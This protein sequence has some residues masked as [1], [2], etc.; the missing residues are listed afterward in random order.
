MVFVCISRPFAK[1]DELHREGIPENYSI[2]SMLCIQNFSW[3]PMLPHFSN[4]VMVR[5]TIVKLDFDDKNIGG[6]I[7]LVSVKPAEFV[8]NSVVVK[9]GCYLRSKLGK[10]T[11]RLSG[12][13][14]PGYLGRC[15]KYDILLFEFLEPFA[16][17]HQLNS[18]EFASRR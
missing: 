5:G 7:A 18:C 15:S 9:A 12:H 8:F 2:P 17:F 6:G 14:R 3:K 11:K 16:E 10:M 13:I 4:Y 1:F